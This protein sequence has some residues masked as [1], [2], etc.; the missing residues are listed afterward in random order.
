MQPRRAGRVTNIMSAT[1]R[2]L[3]ALATV[4]AAAHLARPAQASGFADFAADEDT[5][6]RAGTA[7]INGGSGP[8]A[9][10]RYDFTYRRCMA[11]HGMQRQMGAYADGPPGPLGYH[12]GNP[13]S[14]EYPDAF[15]SVPYATPGYGYDGF[16]W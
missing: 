4:L 5:C 12:N 3:L 1:R 10:Q 8:S 14:F 6:R 13:H 7:A 2:T 9:A 11:S 15:Y 16:G